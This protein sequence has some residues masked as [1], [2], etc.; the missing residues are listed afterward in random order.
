MDWYQGSQMF[1][2][3]VETVYR[4]QEWQKVEGLGKH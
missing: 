2:I 1:C 4:F 3:R